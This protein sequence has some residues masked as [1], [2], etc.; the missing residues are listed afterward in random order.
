M[1]LVE[2]LILLPDKTISYSP[3]D[4][5]EIMIIT[6]DENL[7]TFICEWFSK[8]YKPDG[9]MQYKSSYAKD[10]DLIFKTNDWQV[11]R[12]FNAFPYEVMVSDG[13]DRMEFNL[14]YDHLNIVY[15]LKEYT[16]I[17]NAIIRK[18]RIPDIIKD[19]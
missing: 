7:I 6:T 15:D 11:V 5:G 19:I 14:I 8:L 13:G 12:L 10:I 9:S 18:Y 2:H 16:N 1:S 3:K 17:I 4:R